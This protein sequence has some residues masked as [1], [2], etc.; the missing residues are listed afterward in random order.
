[1]RD[2]GERLKYEINP[3]TTAL[4]G[5]DFQ[6]GFGGGWEP[7]PHA[8]GA[9][10]NFR[11][12]AMA[13]RD[14]GGS[15]VLLHTYYTPERGPV[16]RMIDFVPDAAVALAEESAMTAFYDD[17]VKDGDIL[18]HKN[19]FSAVMSSDLVAQLEQ[20]GFDTV[21]VGGL[22]TPICVQTTVDGLSMTGFKVVVL[23]D[24]CA[25]QPI[26]TMTAEEA[27]AAAIQRM[28]CFFAQVSDTDT[29]IGTARQTVIAT[30]AS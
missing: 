4:V 28:G 23:E 18:V 11:R 19:A 14:I 1:M 2:A 29:F 17:I 25:S 8:A 15:V 24:A 12:A 5:V 22:T 21:V 7:V 20:L 3:Q 16:G 10:G 27:H 26:G 9:V 13:W 30:S 6:V